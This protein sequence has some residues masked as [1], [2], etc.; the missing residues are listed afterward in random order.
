MA[1]A[2]AVVLVP[3]AQAETLD[4]PAVST[5]RLEGGSAPVA[6]AGDVNGDG[7]EDV[8][9]AA[10]LTRRGTVDDRLPQSPDREPAGGAYVV[11]GRPDLGALDLATPGAA[12]FR[13]IG[14]RPGDEAGN[15]VAGAGDFNG[16][17]LADVLLTA[18]RAEGAIRR[19]PGRRLRS[20]HDGAA[21]VV[22]GSRTP[23]DVDLARLGDRG[24]A[25]RGIEEGDAAGIGDFNGDGRADVAIGDLG[26]HIDG[27]ATV[28]LGGTGPGTFDVARAGPRGITVRGASGDLNAGMTVAPA[29]DANGD[30]LADLA[31]GAPTSVGRPL[32]PSERGEN[33]GPGTA[34]VVFGRASRAPIRLGRLAGGGYRIHGK[35]SF[36]FVGFALAGAGDVNGDGRSDTVVGAP[37]HGLDLRRR[38][39]VLG[40]AFVV[41]GSSG[42][43]DVDLDRLGDRGL[44]LRGERAAP[45]A[46]VSVAAAG[47]LNGDGLADVL[48]GATGMDGD[49]VAREEPPTMAYAVF[50]RAAPGS[51]DLAGTRA[52]TGGLA[53][54]GLTGDGLGRN[55]AAADLDGDGRRELV[56]SAPSGCAG[57]ARGFTLFG[58]EWRRTEPRAGGGIYVHSLGSARPAA[59]GALV[60]TGAADALGG[61]PGDDRIVGRA[62][63]DRLSGGAGG[64]CLYGDEGAD[65]LDGGPG[66]DAVFGGTGDD[67]IAGGS[68]DD[69]L[70]GHGGADV[71]DAGAG[72][73]ALDGGA[74]D[75]RLWGGAGRDELDGGT[76][77]D[78]LYGGPGA[79]DIQGGRGND[80]ID[81]RDGAK[82]TIFCG[83]GRDRVRADRRDRVS[84]CEVVRYSSVARSST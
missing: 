24:I 8:I 69:A 16:D 21:Y 6:S 54:R 71:I 29:G 65:A 27:G 23:A 58:G 78:R 11:L 63:D 45:G 46:G 7:R 10:E 64:D 5:G 51:V 25:I 33:V 2:L 59:P 79:D 12:V 42:S 55:V 4:L 1:L 57:G 76:G 13:I 31:I 17:G 53:F 66:G 82:D 15:R 30:G 50:G 81:A 19:I 41:F 80:T 39:P 14:A 67:R 32:P 52:G 83:H 61:G 74:R 43:A 18:P 68:G 73:D 56:L 44:R 28:I 26:S 62:G 60:G 70:R 35:R 47:D 49:E 48:V 34:Y 36:G 22:F 77:N 72:R 20:V 37:V 40:A 3:A 9:V 38:R 75:D 84:G